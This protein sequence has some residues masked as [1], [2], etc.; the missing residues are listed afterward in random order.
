MCSIGSFSSSLRGGSSDQA[1]NLSCPNNGN[2]VEIPSGGIESGGDCSF[3]SPWY[4]T[5]APTDEITGMIGLNNGIL[6][7]KTGEAMNWTNISSPSMFSYQG[8]SLIYNFQFR[9]IHDDAAQPMQFQSF[10][11]F[12]T[13]IREV[14][15]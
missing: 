5:L 12:H 11:A 1:W 2:I 15:Y 14:F 3:T 13:L 7:I 4:T 8:D 9:V 10:H 6:Q